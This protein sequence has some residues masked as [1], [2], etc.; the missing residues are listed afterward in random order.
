[1]FP[2]SSDCLHGFSCCIKTITHIE[3]IYHGRVRI[4]RLRA[5]DGFIARQ[6][7]YDLSLTSI[8]EYLPRYRQPAE[9]SLYCPGHS[10]TATDAYHRLHIN[11]LVQL[12]KMIGG[13]F[14][15]VMEEMLTRDAM[16]GL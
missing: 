6:N 8:K 12:Y 5:C 15:G 2:K 4:V 16:F 9:N 11:M 3:W 13:P 1:M 7:L 10:H 14:F